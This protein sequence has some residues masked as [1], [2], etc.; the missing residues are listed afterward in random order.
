MNE[1]ADTLKC[2]LSDVSNRNKAELSSARTCGDVSVESNEM[3]VYVPDKDILD[4]P[5]PPYPC[6]LSKSFEASPK[7]LEKSKTKEKRLLALKVS[8]ED[9]SPD[10]KNINSMEQKTVS[11]HFV[12]F[13]LNSSLSYAVSDSYQARDSPVPSETFSSKVVCPDNTSDS[14][15]E[16]NNVSQQNL[17]LDGRHVSEDPM[18]HC[19]FVRTSDPSLSPSKYKSSA[20]SFTKSTVSSVDPPSYNSPS[21]PVKFPSSVSGVQFPFTN[22]SYSNSL[23]AF[24]SSLSP[25]HSSDIVHQTSGST[26]VVATTCHLEQPSPSPQSIMENTFKKSSMSECVGPSLSPSF[27]DFGDTSTPQSSNHTLHGDTQT[28]T[29]KVGSYSVS[30]DGVPHS[31]SSQSSYHTSSQQTLP[32]TRPLTTASYCE[33]PQMSTD[34]SIR[35]PQPHHMSSVP[36]LYVSPQP[37]T[38]A[39]SPQQNF[40]DPSTQPATTAS[41]YSHHHVA[42]DQCSQEIA[43]SL[44]IEHSSA[45]V[46][47][48]PRHHSSQRHFSSSHVYGN[49]PHQSGYCQS[50]DSH[51]ELGKDC[52]SPVLP[53][54]SFPFLSASSQ[55]ITNSPDLYANNHSHQSTSIHEKERIDGD[56]NLHS[57]YQPYCGDK[58]SSR[59]L[60]AERSLRSLSPPS[61]EAHF[62]NTLTFANRNNSSMDSCNQLHSQPPST[63]END[64][65]YPHDIEAPPPAY[66]STPT[67]SD[68]S[69]PP[70][71]YVSN[72]QNASHPMNYPFEQDI[73][74]DSQDYS[75]LEHSGHF[76]PNTP[77]MLPL[78]AAPPPI[79]GDQFCL[80]NTSTAQGLTNVHSASYSNSFLSATYEDHNLDEYRPFRDESQNH[81]HAFDPHVDSWK[82]GIG[83]NA[84]VHDLIEKAERLWFIPHQ[85]QNRVYMKRKELAKDILSHTG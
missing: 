71:Q 37:S 23:P 70:P 9:I 21:Q 14:F 77:P 83:E 41:F 2:S 45:S 62:Q 35:S 13:G 54:Y 85:E 63:P 67:S 53:P 17:T 16:L 43:H 84:K 31:Y 76:F 40:F 42:Y 52:Q 65:F 56:K 20:H 46:N 78:P 73:C 50:P 81:T 7:I 64:T 19:S 72:P 74:H 69:L 22:M 60:P 75:P 29:S 82:N 55:H 10:L 11:S 12:P 4:R 26:S 48:Q 80:P 30:A 24:S 39:Q 59:S 61:Y 47:S 27:P 15:T 49:S 44:S 58:F 6:L 79:E 25:S 5:P 8:E 32:Y 3:P 66:S 28:Y 68:L 34:S 57:E 1:N 38:Y 18:Q 36:S 33:S 51:S